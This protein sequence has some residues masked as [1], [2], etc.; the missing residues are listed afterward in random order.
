MQWMSVRRRVRTFEGDVPGI[1]RD[2]SERNLFRMPWLW[3]A[4]LVTVFRFFHAIDPTYDAG[5]QL[6][7][8]RNLLAGHGLSTYAQMGADLANGQGLVT[9]T[10]FPSG[11]S[12]SA[13]ALM[14]MG[15]SVATA[16]KL[17][18]AAATVLG[19]WG[20]SRLARPFFKDGMTR[21]SLWKA[22]AIAI[23]AITPVL[24]TPRWG[25]TDIFLWAI[26]PWAIVFAVEASHDH[27]PQAW[28]L[29]WLT[30]TLCG[31]AVLMRYASLF[32]VV[33]I[34]C[35]MLWQ[36][37]LRKRMLI[38]RWLVFGIGLLPAFVLQAYVNYV[39]SNAVV[40]PGGLF[41]SQQHGLLSR[42]WVGVRFLDTA[43]TFWNFWIPGI[44]AR[45][46]LPAGPGA[47]MWRLGITL[48]AFISFLAVLETYRID[49]KAVARDSRTAALGLFL[50]LPLTLVGC[51][52][53]STA[54]FVADPRYYWSIVPLSVFVAY[55]I[56]TRVDTPPRR[57]AINVLNR[58]CAVYLAAYLAMSL[59][60]AVSLVLP[61]RI[62]ESSRSRLIGT[63]TLPW[64][65]M[66]V[67][68]EFS[69][70]RQLVMQRLKEHPGTLLLTSRAGAFYWDPAVDGSRLYDLDCG[71]LE[72]LSLYISGP[73]R[74][75]IHSF[76][77]GQ[78]QELWYYAS[79]GRHQRSNCFERLPDVHLL[80]RFPAE[81]F[82][83]LEASVAEGQRISLRP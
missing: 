2:S 51:T 33:Y 9:L 34:A 20:W 8:A 19:W 3:P 4:V 53:L 5:I 56:A 7:A 75:L 46:L 80:Q 43:N 74:V 17:L 79:T 62:G 78:P 57:I 14:A 28:R 26:V 11:Y 65:S 6:Q 44:V 22:T 10:Y 69:A 38:R 31:F 39:L 58:V 41:D 25:G 61:G 45:W 15:L 70:A 47:L 54:I 37:W 63:D 82:K 81:G 42:L 76:D 73:A 27:A 29:D 83:V 16:V 23:A 13:A 52:M 35:L 21:S 71:N 59:V 55:S 60:Y 1:M 24:F 30:G 40:T 77:D 50:A 49:I 12:L 68:Y 18:A 64:P 48:V 66:A 67:T 72:P 36:S 32:L